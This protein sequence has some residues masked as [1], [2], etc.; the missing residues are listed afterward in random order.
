MKNKHILSD[1]V[2]QDENYGIE[3]IVIDDEIKERLAS[4]LY[5]DI[6]TSENDKAAKL[7]EIENINKSIHME[8]RSE[9]KVSPWPDCANTVDFLTSNHTRVINSTIHRTMINPPYWVIS[10]P[11]TP[12]F[13]EAAEQG[14]NYYAENIMH[15]G[16]KFDDAIKLTIE[17]STAFGE[18]GYSIK[19]TEQMVTREF[20][21]IQQFY[22]EFIP[23]KYAEYGF[24]SQ[25]DFNDFA[26]NCA[27]KIDNTKSVKVT[28]IKREVN[29]VVDMD[30]YTIDETCI[31]PWNSTHIQKSKGVL[32]RI[33]LTDTDL[34]K[35]ANVDFFDKEAVEKVMA[36][37]PTV[38]NGASTNAREVRFKTAGGSGEAYTRKIFKGVYTCK[39]D[40]DDEGSIAEEVYIYFAWN[41][42]QILRIERYRKVLGERPIVVFKPLSIHNQILGDHIQM[43]LQDAQEKC[44]TL[45]NQILDNNAIANKP[46]FR[47]STEEI[48]E[49]QSTFSNKN[50]FNYFPGCI[51]YVKNNNA[52]GQ[53]QT[54]PLDLRSMINIK[55][56]IY[57]NA[58]VNTGAVDILSGR[59]NAADP[60]APGNKTKMQLMQS[61]MR[62]DEYIS[63]LRKAFSYA[64]KYILNYVINIEPKE[65]QMFQLK[66]GEDNKDGYSKAILLPQDIDDTVFVDT[67]AVSMD[68]NNYTLANETKELMP[69]FL[70]NPVFAQNPR[71]IDVLYRRILSKYNLREKE[72]EQLLEPITIMIKQLE[73]QQTGQLPPPMSPDQFM[74][75][76]QGA[77]QQQQVQNPNA[78]ATGNV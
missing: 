40:D 56:E 18:I 17:E 6:E 47:V 64:G 5:T 60:S 46:S 69:M 50:E 44:N 37:R 41:E 49:P 42:K 3:Q 4:E 33:D 35:Y 21:T 11:E 55:Q 59:E 34:Q 57:R 72:K 23:M 74:A 75:Q 20:L 15:I 54:T 58:Q 78:G 12:E 10:M 62:M 16:E 7:D 19:E 70:S 1:V 45:D 27:K 38:D 65:W 77:G 36:I 25:K 22:E 2:I 29:P 71:V 66:F 52:F 26:L 43:Y 67:R 28:G 73:Q 63:T 13:E 31:I 30:I 24:K 68:Y 8:A 14:I 9:N 76:A 61:T 32:F 39:L 53:N 51:A 48:G